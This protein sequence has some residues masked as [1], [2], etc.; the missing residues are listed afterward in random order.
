[1]KKTLLIASLTAVFVLVTRK[2]CAS[3]STLQTVANV[4]LARYAGLWHEIAR[5]PN[6]FQKGCLATTAT[7][8]LH[9]NQ[10]GVVNSCRNH[11]GSLRQVRGKAWPVAAGNS[12]LKVSFF[13]PLRGDYWI[14]DLDPHY[15]YSVVGTPDRKLLWVLSRSAQMDEAVY[16]GILE[17]IKAQGFDPERLIKTPQ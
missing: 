14:M 1:M 10:L 6:S 8:E 2:S 4:D 12:R 11:D 16:K 15:Q 17:R 7:Y 5:Y 3:T 13:W 9:G